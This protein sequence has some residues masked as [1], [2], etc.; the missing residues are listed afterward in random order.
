M[1]KRILITAIIFM[2]CAGMLKYMDIITN[3]EIGLWDYLHFSRKLNTEERSFLNSKEINYGIAVNDEPFAF[4]ST[5]NNQN[6]GILVDYFNQLSVILESRMQA[7]SYNHYNLAVKLKAGEIDAAVLNKTPMNKEVFLFTQ[8]L[9]KEHGK[10]LVD[11]ES[12]FENITD[13]S[14]ISIAVI[15]GSTAHRAANSTY[16]NNSSLHFV[17]TDSLDESFFLLGMGEVNAILGDEAKIAYHLNQAIKSKRFKFLAGSVYEEDV[18]VAVNKNQKLLCAILNKGILSI[19]KNNQYKHIHS[20]WFGSFVPEIKDFSAQASTANILIFTLVIAFVMLIWNQTVSNRVNLR[21]RELR[22]SRAELRS[23]LDSLMDGIIVTN[24]EGNIQ[25]CN[26]SACKLMRIKQEEA[27]T[28]NIDEIGELAPYLCHANQQEAFAYG[29]K[30]YLIVKREL[31]GVSGKNILIIK[32]YT[33]RHFYERLS[34]QEAKMAAVGELSAGLAHEIRNPLGLIKSYVYII[35]KKLSDEVDAHAFDVIDTSVDRINHLIENLLGFSRLSNEKS[36]NVDIQKLV[37]SVIALERKN[38][39]KNQI[40]ISAE[41]HLEKGSSLMLNEDVLKLI[42]V[43]LINNSIDALAEK[44]MEE[45]TIRIHAVNLGGSLQIDFADNGIGIPKDH[46]ETV[47]NPFFTTKETG[48]GL[49]LY[50]LNSE[51]QNK[52]GQITVESAEG[53]GTVFHILLPEEVENERV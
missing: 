34:R 26:Q 42:L 33:Q 46:L 29:G 1:K 10:I 32:D 36:V 7:V 24:S 2:V 28:E 51:I 41:F 3:Y 25:V 14:N 52:G 5:A 15:A 11:G 31:D 4:V 53:K 49:G 6:S 22:E 39:E 30:Y 48:T 18:A 50:I 40:H 27:F 19:K 16:K 37:L 17:L 12:Q 44:S 8:P 47:F 35:R 9:Y 13:I 43:N 23:I 20:K 21:T 38:L 45:K